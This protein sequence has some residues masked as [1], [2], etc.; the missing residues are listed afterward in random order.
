MSLVELKNPLQAHQGVPR[1]LT[2]GR[3]ELS[4]SG[5]QSKLTIIPLAFRD[6]ADAVDRL[7]RHHKRPTGHKFSLGVLDDAGTLRGAAIVGRPVARCFDDGWQLEVTRV[8]TDGAP[9]ACSTLYG[10]AWRTASAAGYLRLITYTQDGESGAS[11]RAVGW[12]QVAVLRPRAG[13]DTPS[14]PRRD[15]GTDNV[16]RVLWEQSRSGAAALPALAELRN[17]I[18]NEILCE[19]PGCGRPF[20]LRPGPGRPARFCSTT[21]RVRAHRAAKAAA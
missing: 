20:P 3:T 5:R 1:T 12:K 11:L 15:R 4:A 14:R 2:T 8:A 18:R 9:N 10:A 17:E 16:A 6:A 19:G 21:C 7:H 13:W